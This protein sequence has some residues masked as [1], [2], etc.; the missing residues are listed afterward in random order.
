EL[1]GFAG[2]AEIMRTVLLVPVIGACAAFCLDSSLV[3]NLDHS[4]AG[5]LPD[6]CLASRRIEVVLVP[7]NVS[8][9]APDP[10]DDVGI[11]GANRRMSHLVGENVH[12]ADDRRISSWD[13]LDQT[14][15]VNGQEPIFPFHQSAPG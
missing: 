11:R 13:I 7:L 10:H 9:I 2:H 14:V 1:K 15:I 3:E 4:L 6:I 5:I 12:L 8:L